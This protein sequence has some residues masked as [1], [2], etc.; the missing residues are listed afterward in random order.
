MFL[1]QVS[2]AKKK[3]PKNQQRHK[4]PNIPSLQERDA[5]MLRVTAGMRTGP[6][7]G[8][9]A[10]QCFSPGISGDLSELSDPRPA[11]QPGE[12]PRGD[13]RSWRAD[14]AHLKAGCGRSAPLVPPARRTDS[15][16][17]VVSFR[18]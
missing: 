18:P 14:G 13:G 11:T 10:S 4:N 7:G 17:Y 8:Q 5:L 6:R 16:I 3:K 9:H 12:R 1:C 2:S 15:C